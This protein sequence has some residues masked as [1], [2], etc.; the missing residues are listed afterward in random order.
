MNLTEMLTQQLSG[1]ALSHISEKIGIDKETAGSALAAALPVLVSALARK[2]STPEGAE[3]IHQSVTT[4][5]TGGILDDVM[6]FLTGGSVGAGAD[7]L[8]Q[9]LGNQRGAIENG[10]ANHTGLNAGAIGQIL[11]VAA[12][13]VMGALSK[14]QTEQGLD[15]GGLSSY[16]GNQHQSVQDVAS[17]IMNT[18]FNLLDTNHDGSVIDDI[19]RIAGKLFSGQK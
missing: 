5:H 4:Q 12:P 15:A 19:G 18:L 2:S 17:P 16:L 10:I 6:G 13:L 14:K 11:E 9:I 1:D 7:I 3:A 8:S